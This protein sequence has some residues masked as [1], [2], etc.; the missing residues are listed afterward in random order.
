MQYAICMHV[1]GELDHWLIIEKQKVWIKHFPEGKSDSV[2]GIIFT[3]NSI[4]FFV[5]QGIVSFDPFSFYAEMQLNGFAS[6][7]SSQQ[8]SP[9]NNRQTFPTTQLWY[10]RKWIVENL[11]NFVTQW[12]AILKYFENCMRCAHHSYCDHQTN[13]TR[14]AY[15]HCSYH[16]FFVN[17]R[18]LQETRTRKS[19]LHNFVFNAFIFHLR[20]QKL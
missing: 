9:I 18:F 16:T 10:I 14:K 6:S 11:E 3:V 12:L 17:E 4:L 20:C 1:S 8:P 5:R 2:F 7:P 19:K 15:V 13:E